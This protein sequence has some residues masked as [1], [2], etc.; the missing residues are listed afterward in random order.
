MSDMNVKVRVAVVGAAGYSG[1]ELLRILVS[2]PQV[3]LV[4][5]AGSQDSDQT[6]V[7]MFPYLYG[8]KN[9]TIRKFSVEECA[10]RAEAVFVA[11]PSGVS[12]EVAAALWKQGKRVIDLSGDLRLPGD[13]YQSWYEKSPVAS[14]VV[15]EAVY[16]LTEW[17]RH[18]LHSASLVANPGCYATTVLLG[19][20]PLMRRG[21]VQPGSPLI[22]D[23]KSGVSGAGR[24]AVLR[25]QLGELAEN[26]YPYRVG[27]HQ[28]IPEIEQELNRVALQSAAAG[29]IAAD[30]YRVLLN[31]QLLPVVR[32]IHASSYVMVDR[33]TSIAEIYQTYQEAYEGEEFVQVLAPGAVPELK[34]VRGSNQCRISMAMNERTG[35]LQVFSVLDN[36]QKGAA[37]QA[38]QN[39]NV[40]YGFPES[41]GL[42]QMPVYP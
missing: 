22:V 10:E 15:G 30:L 14:E 8:I 42:G 29:G 5:V 20:L 34:H 18:Q 6:L 36:L 41:M 40:M 17:H 12:G 9:L 28:H 1:Q 24:N 25:H 11:L 39:F 38:V 31:T 4:Y 2:H 33:D 23:A 26:F 37:G 27:R 16:G 32:G 7:E 13:I 19:L 35:L 21:L 3:E